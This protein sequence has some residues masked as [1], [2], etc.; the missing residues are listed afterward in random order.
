MDKSQALNSFWSSFGLPAY[1]VNSVPTDAAMPYI[2]YETAVDSIESVLNLQGNIWYRQ[3]SWADASK[4][5]DEISEYLYG[6]WPVTKKIDGGRM[7][8]T[9]GTPFAQRMGDDDDMIKRIVINIQVEF[10][11]AF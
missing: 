11:T 4:K 3:I 2:T 5:A 10:L 1:D 8:I 9:K 7:F 6:I